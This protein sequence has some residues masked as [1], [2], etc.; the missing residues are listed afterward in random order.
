[1]LPSNTL[2]V[3]FDI[4]IVVFND[5]FQMKKLKCQ[6][7]KSTMSIF[8]W[9]MRNRVSLTSNHK[10]APKLCLSFWLPLRL[11]SLSFVC[12]FAY[13]WLTFTV[14]PH[15]VSLYLLH[16]W[17]WLHTLFSASLLKEITCSFN[18]ETVT[19]LVNSHRTIS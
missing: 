3:A 13:I 7:F 4:I 17:I 8:L 2:T 18:V 1:M 12:V 19:K 16:V 10:S 11:W 6:K 5:Y 14:E 9:L 15:P